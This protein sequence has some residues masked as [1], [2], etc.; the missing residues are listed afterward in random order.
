M[1]RK[2]SRAVEYLKNKVFQRTATSI[3]I[4]ERVIGAI[5]I[6]NSERKFSIRGRHWFPQLRQWPFVWS[7]RLI[8]TITFQHCA[9]LAIMLCRYGLCTILRPYR[10]KYTFFTDSAKTIINVVV[11]ENSELKVVPVPGQV[12]GNPLHDCAFVLPAPYESARCP[13]MRRRLLQT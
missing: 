2:L 13:Q 11:V 10:A 1:S 3:Y 7:V 12:T 9:V 8:S 4:A 5:K 6:F